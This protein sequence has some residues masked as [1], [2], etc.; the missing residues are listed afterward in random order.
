MDIQL[1]R[2]RLVEELANLPDVTTPEI[3]SYALTSAVLVR[4]ITETL[5]IADLRIQDAWRRETHHDLARVLN[6][7][8]HY[9]D[10]GRAIVKPPEGEQY[11]D[12]YV[13]LRSERTEPALVIN[14]G[15]YFD[16]VRRFA[17]DDIFVVRY[18]L[19]RVVALLSHVVRQPE[20]DFDRHWLADV[21]DRIYDSFALLGKLVRRRTLVVPTHRAINGYPNVHDEDRHILPGPVAERV[22][23]GQMFAEY[24]T[25]YGAVWNRSIGRAERYRIGGSEIYMVGV[26]RLP[27]GAPNAESVFFKLSDL[28]GMFNDLWQQVGTTTG[29]A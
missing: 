13:Y 10:F 11:R 15:T 1:I 19:R 27:A 20:R 8:V 21:T 22:P 16:H 7:I 17:Y 4:R 23:Y 28:L 25:R 6:K 14:L 5:N 24:G 9:Q 2:N 18:L 26:S 12:D 3:Q 29:A